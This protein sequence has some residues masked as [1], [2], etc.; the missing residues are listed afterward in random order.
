MKNNPFPKLKVYQFLKDTSLVSENAIVENHKM[1]FLIN[2]ELN[3]EATIFLSKVAAAI[4]FN[5]ESEV[6][7]VQINDNDA[8][9]IRN[10]KQ[11]NIKVVLLFGIFPK[12][13]EL[14]IDFA[15]YR[16]ISFSNQKLIFSHS[17]TQVMPKVE[18]K[19]QL[20]EGLKSLELN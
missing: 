4:G 15:P 7:V 6:Q 16:V 20:W 3:E 2:E 13:L 10:F 14:N 12:Q 11:K 19:K 8:F 5:F 17:I 1:L 9:P 18:Y